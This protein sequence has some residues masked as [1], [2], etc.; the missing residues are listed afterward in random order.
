MS[1]EKLY[2]D[3]R[4]I[5]YHGDTNADFIRFLA[6]RAA[7][8]AFHP[9]V[10]EFCRDKT[11]EQIFNVAKNKIEYR[12]DPRL[13]E[14]ILS[15]ALIIQ[16]L[17][18]GRKVQ[19]DCDGKTL[20]LASCLANMGYHVN[21]IGALFQK[22]GAT[23]INHVFVEFLDD[24]SD[25]WI[26]LEPSTRILGFGQVSPRAVPVLKVALQEPNFKKLSPHKIAQFMQ[27]ANEVGDITDP[28]DKDECK[29]NKEVLWEL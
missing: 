5:L 6:K 2:Q 27:V 26:Q 18:K 13:G 20:F 28:V 4:I 17:R 1:V 23:G 12:R 14:R 10:D 25:Q 15:P 9:V 21:I 22:A 19:E 8:Y 11:P 16:E 29:R 3:D 7:F 24:K